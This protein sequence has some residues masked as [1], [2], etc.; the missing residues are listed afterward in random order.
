MKR[1]FIAIIL[2]AIVATIS[3]SCVRKSGRRPAP[4]FETVSDTLIFTPEQIGV[5][6]FS[7]KFIPYPGFDNGTSMKFSFSIGMKC[8]GKIYEVKYLK[9]IFA[10]DDLSEE[11]MMEKK[12]IK[13]AISTYMLLRTIKSEDIKVIIVK[14]DVIKI[15][16]E[17]TFNGLN[18][19]SP[20][21]VIWEK[22]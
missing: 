2:V 8:D 13:E 11:K 16:K 12:E 7:K 17:P 9:G 15:T 18:E 22:I 14:G 4:K 10:H 19:F 1:L 5:T 6:D 21:Q 3:T 20:A